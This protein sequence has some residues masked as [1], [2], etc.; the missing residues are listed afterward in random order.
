MKTKIQI[1]LLAIPTVF[2]SCGEQTK[3]NYGGINLYTFREELKTRPK[4]V[5]KSIN[6]IGY[7][8][9]EEVGYLE[10]KFYGMSPLEYK[11]YLNEIGM[12]PVSSHQSGITYENASQ[13]IEDLKT[14]GYQ[15]LVIPIPPMGRFTFDPDTREM[16]M[17]GSADSLAQVLNFLGKKCDEA[18]LKLLY[19]NHDFEFRPGEDGIIP[20]DYLLEH[21]DPA[22]VN[23]E[24]DLYWAAKAGADPIAY[25]EKHPGRFKA[26][27]LKDMDDQGRFAPVGKGQ[28]D[29][30]KYLAEK[31]LA[32]M[33]YYFVEQDMT[34]DGMT[35]YEAVKISHAAI[36]NLGFE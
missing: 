28:L 34:F 12:V 21:T 36:K 1:I 11:E 14:V 2:L 32:G 33:E 20:I 29:F 10:R 3:Q 17:T 23:F 30:A 13:T 19:H 26:W 31:D 5:L 25:F 24:L 27:H 35:P 15:Y 18:G 6:D 22:L 8:N 9:V 7:R 4:E 16:G